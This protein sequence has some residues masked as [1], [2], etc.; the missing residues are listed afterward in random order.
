M[1]GPVR[2]LSQLTREGKGLREYCLASRSACRRAGCQWW[3]VFS[4]SLRWVFLPVR[5]T[6]KHLNDETTSKQIK[7]MLQWHSRASACSDSDAQFLVI[8]ITLSFTLALF[9][10]SVP[11]PSFLIMFL[12]LR[13]LFCAKISQVIPWRG[14]LSDRPPEAAN[15]ALHWGL[16]WEKF[17]DLN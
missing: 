16:H 11:L 10:P 3:C 7:S 8:A 5:Y 9:L 13:L 12:F 17:Y 6:T 15:H 1:G 2:S 4:N 14:C